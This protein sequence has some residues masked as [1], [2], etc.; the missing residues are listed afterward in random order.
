M[1]MI[2]SCGIRARCP[3]IVE[4]NS[5]P[6]KVN[7]RLIQY[8]TG[9]WGSP[10][11]IGIKMAIV[12]PKGRDLGKRQVDEDDAALDD[13]R[14]IRVNPGQNQLAQNGAAARNWSIPLSMFVLYFAPLFLMAST[15]RL[16][17]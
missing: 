15:S 4:N 2:A 16:R 6:T 13:V 17:S 8:T 12:A 1:P 3:R 9:A 5:A 14:Q 11:V 7:A 10:P